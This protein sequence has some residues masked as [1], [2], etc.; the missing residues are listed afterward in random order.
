MKM[1]LS[2]LA[3]ASLAFTVTATA[4]PV[5]V[6]TDASLEGIAGPTQTP[7]GTGFVEVGWLNPGTTQAQI[8]N[9]FAS[10]DLVF[11]DSVFNTVVS[12]NY[13][14]LLNSFGTGMV[15]AQGEAVANGDAP[16]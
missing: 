2:K 4:V 13:T 15:F 16:G 8:F 9:A 14:P 5:V 1:T 11:I 7:L 12:F 10:G 6:N 3:L